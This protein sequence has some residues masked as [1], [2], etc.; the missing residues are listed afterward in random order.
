MHDKPQKEATPSTWKI[1][2]ILSVKG[3]LS[4]CYFLANQQ[5]LKFFLKFA[6]VGS[7][8][9]HNIEIIF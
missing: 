1:E 4:K 6:K 9:M 8:S 5:I 3:H 2:I 7:V